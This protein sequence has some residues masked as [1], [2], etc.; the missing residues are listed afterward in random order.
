MKHLA[1]VVCATLF[2]CSESSNS[3]P[4][5]VGGGLVEPDAAPVPGGETPAPGGDAPAPG[6]DAPPPVGGDAP[7]PVG[8]D[9]PPLPS[10]GEAPP[11]G[12]D[13]PPVGGDVPP[14]FDPTDDW[15]ALTNG[16]RTFNS[17]DALPSSLVVF[18]PEA[19]AVLLDE[20]GRPF[21]AAARH[22]AGRV[23]LYGHEAPLNG[24]SGQPDDNGRLLENTFGWI[25]A[26]QGAPALDIL[27]D[28][29][30]DALA[31]DLRALGHTPR[32]GGYQALP[33]QA[34]VT[35]T[36]PERTAEER[37]AIIAHVEG[38]GGLVVGG[39][40]WWWSYSQNNP[41]AA[42]DY[43]G[44]QFLVPMGLLV[45]P[46]T[47]V[48]AGLDMV[49]DS[50]PDPCTN[51]RTAV[52]ALRRDQRE[53]PA[54]TPARRRLCAARATAG[55]AGLPLDLD[56]FFEVVEALSA[57]VG[58]V[59]PTEAAPLD[60]QAQPTERVVVAY[61]TRLA[62]E[63]PV[64]AVVASPMAV[65]FP[66]AVA[67]GAPTGEAVVTLEPEYVGRPDAF[68]YSNPGSP[69]W[70]STGLYAAPGE[71][72]SATAE[73]DAEGLSVQIGAHTDT[74]WDLDSW[75]RAPALVR[76]G[77]FSEGTVRIANGFGGPIYVRQAIGSPRA[78]VRVVVTGGT[79][80]RHYVHGRTDPATWQ[81]DRGTSAAPWAELETDR[82]TH[83]VPTD[84][85][86]AADDPV[87]LA[88]TWNTLLDAQAALSG[89]PVGRARAERF[90]FDR[91]ISA[92]WMH[93]GYPIMAHLPSVPEAVDLALI[94]RDG[95]WGPL[96]ELGHNHQWIDWVLPGTTEG[97]VNLFS[98][99]A[100][101]EVLGIDRGRA[102]PALDPAE[103]EARIVEFLAGGRRFE[104]WS[105]WTALET[106]LQ[107]EERFG[108]APFTALFVEYRGLAD[109]ERP[110][111]EAAAVQAWVVR[112][113]RAFG[114]DLTDFY[115]AW[116]FPLT[117]ETRDAV[118]DLP[119]WL[120]HPMAGR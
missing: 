89:L 14:P 15:R 103:R 30:L 113:S 55:V 11:V 114:F 87:A 3:D 76:V 18:G 119:A 13:V 101:E 54:L 67:R 83:L 62:L 81:A 43:P 92:G 116:G 56:T 77:D 70:H 51:V 44:N 1:L 38:G 120:D 57:E 39:Q 27:L 35:T 118:G 47:D 82:V 100:S 8:G 97:N 88:E 98:V 61:A 73:G 69:L 32:F 58:E 5:N 6:G 94:R 2:A 112:S 9:T 106:Y 84:A 110:A 78:V 50:P 26:A 75:T 37:D 74:L 80:M 17:G 105:V 33:A 20:S 22:G 102:H 31:D 66:G 10:G 64:D 85:L 45:T 4:Q 28:P 16:V 71:V 111:D 48:T 91:Q 24:I 49:G 96:H 115:G 42:H 19:F 36:Y 65:D 117:A 108:W 109:P 86:D 79:P 40:A 7:P 72:V 63:A 104:D 21:I 90:V 95:I 12:G 52:D 59:I 46:N 107:L 99:Y 25:A 41:D 34:W 93:S 68:A 29:G 60:A 23:V 53:A